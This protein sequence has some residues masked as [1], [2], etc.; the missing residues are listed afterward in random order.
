MKTLTFMD[1][2]Y[3]AEKIIKTDSEV[4]GLNGS[5]VVFAFHGITDF[6]KFTLADGQEF[7][8][9]PATAE[10]QQI[11]QILLE[12]TKMKQDIAALKGASS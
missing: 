11:A 2:Q 9:E 10:Q 6:S 4:I 1:E 3:Q 5:T 8:A 12:Q 7:D